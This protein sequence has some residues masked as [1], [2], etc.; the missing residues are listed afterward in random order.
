MPKPFLWYNVH[1]GTWGY[2]YGKPQV[3][4]EHW[5]ACYT[6]SWV[7]RL[8]DCAQSISS[9]F[10]EGLGIFFKGSA[11]NGDRIF[12]NEGYQ[13]HNFDPLAYPAIPLLPS[14]T[15][16]IRWIDSF[17]WNRIIWIAASSLTSVRSNHRFWR[18][19]QWVRVSQWPVWRW[20]SWP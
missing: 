15:P 2:G 11:N 19:L 6:V 16:F 10:P 3:S 17:N 12:K 8:E 14:G 18:G 5:V 7:L 9:C 20:A 1:L 4:Y 13:A